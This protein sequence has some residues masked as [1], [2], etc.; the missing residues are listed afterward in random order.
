MKSLHKLFPAYQLII[1]GICLFLFTAGYFYCFVF[2][3][4]RFID[5]N[6]ILLAFLLLIFSLNIIFPV[7]TPPTDKKKPVQHKNLIY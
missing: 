2:S 5:L 3:Y 4:Q 1:A 6:L 7:D